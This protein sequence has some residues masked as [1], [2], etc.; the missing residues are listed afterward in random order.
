MSAGPRDLGL[1]LDND[2]P[3]FVPEPERYELAGLLDAP[4]TLGRRDFLRRLGGGLVIL[5]TVR[6]TLAPG[7]PQAAAAPGG[8]PS[9]RG[10]R[11]P[12]QLAAWL[13][14]GPDGLVTAYTGKVEIGQNARA[15]LTA[16][17]AEELHVPVDRVAIVM[18]DTD[19]VPRDVGTFGSLT[20]PVMFLQIRRAAAAARLLLRDRAAE[21]WGVE[22][23]SITARDGTL[24]HAASGRSVAYGALTKGEE[25]VEEIAGDVP[26]ADPAAWTVAGT[27]L[28]KRDAVAFV[29]GAHRYPSDLKR[30]GMRHGKVLRPPAQGA[31]LAAIDT[32][33]AAA[34]P[35]VAVVRDGEFVGVIAPDDAT[36]ARALAA[37]R[38]SWS[39]P[40]P[41]CTD[42]T[43]ADHLRAKARPADDDRGRDAA[44]SIAAGRG[45]SAV[46]LER[47]Y[48]C[49]YIAH[50]PLEPRA[51]VAEWEGGRVTIW[52][53]T[54]VPFGVRGG[55]ARALG[56]GEEDVRIVV[57]ATGSGYG[58]KHTPESA[59]EA[60]RLARAAG[61]PVR[62]AWTREEEFSAAYLRPAGVVEVSAGA[63]RDGGL[64]F[65]DYRNINSGTAGLG[66]PYRVPNR[67]VA[68]VPS[69]SPLR[70]GS[71]RALASTFNHFARESL[72][73]ELAR[74][75]KLDPLA[76]RLKNL[77]NERLIAALKAGAERF[78]WGGPK[79]GPGRGVGLA[80][81]FD[82][83]GIC[84]TFVEIAV[85]PE[86]QVEVVRVVAVF[87]AGAIVNPDGLENQV[88]GAVVQGIGGALF[89]RIQFRDGR[90]RNG[91][92]ARYRLPRF[93]DV[94]PIDVVLLDRKDLPPAGGGEIPIVGI[95]PAIANAIH[96]ATGLRLR[97]MPLVPDRLPASGA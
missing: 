76:F 30:P 2:P 21:A 39:N 44:G 42:A 48:T 75:L 84:A 74:E 28:P 52:T 46:A 6:P 71:Y 64:T 67:N 50:A 27:T 41:G 11:P 79:A 12:R 10:A 33:A 8:D 31:T 95:A 45:A 13:H 63:D 94:P 85:T 37:L 49:A 14:V 20:T 78:G 5:C 18:G 23:G 57:P 66:P 65:W 22:P 77:D 83:G 72:V 7:A 87:E 73:D 81:G 32:T 29:T 9:R 26:L 69:D 35:G 80:C 19:Q 34:M 54:Q 53:G 97:A 60:A 89:E 56:V 70:Q 40:A 51:A 92:F 88:E 91:R 17:V 36:A 38:P 58:G 68:F 96:D 47:V 1:D 43:L 62:V 90:L 3:D 59:I 61:A 25:L 82:K 4:A 24:A 93:R 15:S 86:R 16:A 55:V